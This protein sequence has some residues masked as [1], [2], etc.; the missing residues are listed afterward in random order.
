MGQAK[1]RGTFEQRQAEAIKANGMKE[2][3]EDAVRSYLERKRS[4]GIIP[5]LLADVAAA[6]LGS[7]SDPFV[8]KNYSK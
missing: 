5:I 4:P 7:L 1:R 6:P 2:N 3:N 8:Y